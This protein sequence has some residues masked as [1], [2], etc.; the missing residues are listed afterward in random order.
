MKN[1]HVS[2][3]RSVFNETSTYEVHVKG[4]NALGEANST[5][6]FSVLNSGKR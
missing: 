5:F 1:G 2:I 6:T 3:P 4:R